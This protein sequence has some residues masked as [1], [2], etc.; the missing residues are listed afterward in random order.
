M[1]KSRL[2]R[3]IWRDYYF[4]RAWA[5]TSASFLG[6]TW[7]LFEIDKANSLPFACAE[8]CKQSLIGGLWI[9][10][11]AIMATPLVIVVNYLV[12]IAKRK[13]IKN[14][15][16]IQK[17]FSAEFASREDL[18]EVEAFGRSLVGDSHVDLETLKRRHRINPH[19][20]TCLYSNNTGDKEGIIGYYILYPLT[21]DAY[22]GIH[23]TEIVNG[24]DIQDQHI[25]PSF[26]DAAALYIG[27]LGG[28][29]GHAD[30]YVI[31]EMLEQI[32]AILHAGNLKALCTRGTTPDGKRVVQS[33]GFQKLSEPSEIS[34]LPVTREVLASKRIKRHLAYR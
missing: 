10:L 4:S 22:K 5:G 12:T 30:G 7:L 25:S 31:E 13:K 29:G 14:R 28:A 1:K 27:M 32:S 34:C 20:V 2:R 19:I 11:T 9:F 26:S 18:K 33:F 6:F 21:L 15:V 3:A 16:K 8:V 17:K 23:C 24:R